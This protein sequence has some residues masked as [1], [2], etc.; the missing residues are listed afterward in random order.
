MPAHSHPSDTES[1]GNVVLCSTRSD[2]QFHQ[3]ALRLRGLK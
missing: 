2:E 3:V 1:S